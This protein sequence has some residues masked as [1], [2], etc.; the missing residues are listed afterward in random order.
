MRQPAVPGRLR[1]HGGNAGRAFVPPAPPHPARRQP[2]LPGRIG[3]GARDL[4]GAGMGDGFE[5]R[6]QRHDPLHATARGDVQ[7]QG[8]VGA[9]PPLGLDA[10]KQQEPG[11]ALGWLPGPQRDPR[12]ADRALPRGVQAH[13]RPDRGKVDERLRV[14]RGERRGRRAGGPGSAARPSPPPRHRPSPQTPPPSW[15]YWIGGSP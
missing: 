14:D 6:A 4:R 1:D 10:A 13:D 3:A 15:G 2:R 8:G 5:D 9:P 7:Q 12:P 11:T